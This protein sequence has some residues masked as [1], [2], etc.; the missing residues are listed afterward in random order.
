MENVYFPLIDMK[1]HARLDKKEDTVVRDQLNE[2]VKMVFIEL[3][4]LHDIMRTFNAPK[5]DKPAAPKRKARDI[6]VEST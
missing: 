1:Q 6:S 4:T 3:L 5:L 2:M